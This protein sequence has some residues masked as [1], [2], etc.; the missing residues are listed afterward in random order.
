V[1]DAPGVA[2]VL[3]VA[4]GVDGIDHDSF[5]GFAKRQHLQDFVAF[6]DRQDF[7]QPVPLYGADDAAAEPAFDRAQ[8]YV[9]HGEA[10]VHADVVV[11]RDRWVGQHD[12]IARRPLALHRAGPILQIA[13]PCQRGEDCR[14]RIAIGA[15]DVAQRLHVARRSGQPCKID[16]L[17][18]GGNI[19]RHI[20]VE[21]PIAAILQ[22][23]VSEHVISSREG[24]GSPPSKNSP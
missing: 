14:V 11:D 7:A 13:G 23:K 4:I 8:K 15:E 10:M 22:H 24:G 19:D 18:Q 3:D 16:E 6:R 2:P 5:L 20:L 1:V 9:L 17:A 21:T 12:D